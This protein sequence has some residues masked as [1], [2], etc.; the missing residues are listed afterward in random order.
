MT[1]L[2]INENVEAALSYVLGIIS[3]AAVLLFE[4]ES[5]FARFHAMQSIMLSLGYIIARVLVEILSIPFMLIPGG[6]GIGIAIAI[7]E[8]VLLIFAIAWIA[9]IVKAL[10]G[11]WFKLPVIGDFAEKALNSVNV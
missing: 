10:M 2:G 4:K 6:A 8:I 7:D 9:C 5:R 3:G 11:E 1:S